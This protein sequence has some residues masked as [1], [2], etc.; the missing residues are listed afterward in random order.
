[1]RSLLRGV[2][3][4]LLL[5]ALPVLPV[6]AA[7]VVVEGSAAIRDGDLG[8]ARELATRRAFARAAESQGA[9][10]NAQSTL[11]EGMLRETSQLRSRACTGESRL[12]GETVRDGELTVTLRVTVLPAEQCP[13]PCQRSTVNRIAVTGFAFEFPEQILPTEK[14]WMASLTATETARMIRERRRLLADFDGTV[15][16]YG[17]PA[18]APEPFLTP[19]DRETS[20]LRFAREHRAQYVL[21]GVYRDFGLS[22]GRWGAQRRRI[23]IEAFLHD[24]GNGALLA[25]Q[26]FSAE[27]SGRVLLSDQPSV[28][29]AAFYAGDFGRAW[30]GV[31]REIAAWA[32]T[33]SACLPFIARVLKIEGK[34]LHLDAGAES[35]LSTGDTLNLHDLKDPE[36]RALSGLALG[37]EKQARTTVAIRAVYPRF[38]VAEVISVPPAGPPGAASQSPP[39]ARIRPG[40]LLYGE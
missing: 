35:G 2:A 17:T 25:Q 12:L 4:T 11:R 9:V 39:P 27:A 38:A 21:S 3:L 30:G 8:A 37:Q 5:A 32:E 36:V 24:G 23:E 18:R 34:T 40:D 6:R 22:D 1:M 20:L 10:V 15:F 33:K 14:P 29:S 16:P 19:A 13:A 26:R 7:D 31:L 28:G